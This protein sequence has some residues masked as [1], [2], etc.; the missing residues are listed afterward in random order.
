MKCD[1]AIRD[2]LLASSGELDLAQQPRL[3]AHLAQCASCRAYK[4]T[5]TRVETAV[6]QE[7]R[8][9][10]VVSAITADTILTEITR[11]SFIARQRATAPWLVHPS[12][13]VAAAML[14]AF[15]IG[16]TAVVL[17]AGLFRSPLAESPVA[18]RGES[19]MWS[20]D[21]WMDVQIDLLFDEADALVRD[22]QRPFERTFEPAE[23][24]DSVIQFEDV[25]DV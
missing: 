5:L 1:E 25:L 23:T 13:S 16:F 8:A 4:K 6:Q 15:L 22:L 14:V 10:V 18:Q 2:I 21:E 20:L 9:E 24:T 7:S 19:R 17:W 11:R 12:W 3:T